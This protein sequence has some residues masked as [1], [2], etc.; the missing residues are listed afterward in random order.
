MRRELGQTGRGTTD[1]DRPH[2]AIGF[3]RER[4]D[5]PSLGDGQQQGPGRPLPAGGDAQR[6]TGQDEAVALPRA[7]VEPEPGD[8]EDVRRRRVEDERILQLDRADRPALRAEPAL[9]D[10]RLAVETRERPRDLA[11]RAPRGS[12]WIAQ[13]LS[14]TCL[15]T[16]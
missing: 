1:Q 7:I 2:L 9:A 14:I 6:A 3:A 16:V 10:D 4:R 13:I 8:R 11:V 15:T 5:R 12:R